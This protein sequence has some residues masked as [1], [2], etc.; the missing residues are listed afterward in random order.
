L[1]LILVIFLRLAGARLILL[2]PVLFLSGGLIALRI[3]HLDGI[4]RWDFPWATGIGLVCAQIGAGLHYWPLAP[5]QVGLALTGALY[6]LTAFS[7][8]VTE[9]LPL[10]RAALEPGLILALTW[11]AAIFLR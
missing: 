9:G 1:F 11:G 7:A 2:I 3:L 8:N 4:D 10:R 5:L 6:A